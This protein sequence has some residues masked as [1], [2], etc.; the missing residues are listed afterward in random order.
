MK[1]PSPCTRH[2]LIRTDGNPEIATGHLRRCLSIAEAL[3]ERGA[4]VEFALADQVSAGLFASFAPN[5]LYPV[6]VLDT[7]YRKPG[8]ELKALGALLSGGDYDVLL[9]DSY[10]VTPDYLTALKAMV[11]TA[12]LDDLCAF[13]YPADL[14]INY[15]PDPPAD[16]YTKAGRLLAGYRYT[17]LRRQFQGI[18]PRIRDQVENVLLS[19]GGTDDPDIAGR[20]MRELL[21]GERMQ[22]QEKNPLRSNPASWNYHILAGPMN[23]H[24]SG[25]ER[26]AQ[27]HPNVQLY[28]NVSRMADLM[29]ECDLAVSAAGTTLYELCAAGLPTVSYTLADNQLASARGME[30]SASLPWAGDARSDPRL[31]T[32]IAG[33]LTELAQDKQKRQELSAAMHACVDGNGAARI[34]QELCR[35]DRNHKVPARR[36]I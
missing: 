24:R 13:D 2:I 7:D 5:G 18:R 34:A 12:Y 32:K 29:A 21:K 26:L 14:V 6:H 31:P 33:I 23:R 28:E 36:K 8:E 22:V 17:P 11:K 16:F 10:F 19:T 15:D 27:D 3:S 20:L 9:V 1:D 25:L 4:G 35:M 30:S